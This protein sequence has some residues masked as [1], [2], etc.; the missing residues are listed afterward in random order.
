M[1]KVFQWHLLQFEKVNWKH[2]ITEPILQDFLTLFALTFLEV[3]DKRQQA[4][5]NA[6]VRIHPFITHQRAAA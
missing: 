2:A 4:K 1:T 5:Y 6:F 3:Q